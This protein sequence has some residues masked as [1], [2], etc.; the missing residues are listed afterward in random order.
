MCELYSCGV[1]TIMVAGNCHTVYTVSNVYIENIGTA[2][3]GA[4]AADAA[5]GVNSLKILDGTEDR[6]PITINTSDIFGSSSPSVTTPANLVENDTNFASIP[7]GGHIDIG[8]GP[9]TKI[10]QVSFKV[11]NATDKIKLKFGNS[12]GFD[13]SSEQTVVENTET[14]KK[15]YTY[16][17]GKWT[18][19]T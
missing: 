2:A 7:T 3:V 4:T 13:G 12:S 15:T 10:S 8:L 17:D 14:N 5:I 9:G 18:F 19:S 1:G 16:D 6:E 11:N